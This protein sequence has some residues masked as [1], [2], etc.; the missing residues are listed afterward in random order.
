MYFHNG[1]IYHYSYWIK[2][3][4]FN[5]MVSMAQQGAFGSAVFTVVQG[6]LYGLGKDANGCVVF[7]NTNWYILNLRVQQ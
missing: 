4:G 1:F 5:V 7:S 2:W 3:T 6:Q